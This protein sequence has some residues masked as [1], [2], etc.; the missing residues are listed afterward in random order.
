MNNYDNYGPQYRAPT[1]Q[2]SNQSVFGT[3]L[4]QPNNPQ[5][6]GIWLD[7]LF[8]HM[9][10]MTYTVN[11]Q[12]NRLVCAYDLMSC[13]ESTIANLRARLDK[14]HQPEILKT[15]FITEDKINNRLLY[16]VIK[17]D[18]SPVSTIVF[19]NFI[20]TSVTIC[21][22]D[23]LYN[24]ENLLLIALSNGTE[25]KVG[26]DDLTARKII[27]AM[28]KNGVAFSLNKKNDVIGQV[29]VQYLLPYIDSAK[30]IFI[31]YS[32][33]WLKISENKYSYA[34]C[35]PNTFEYTSPYFTNHFIPTKNID[36][37]Y[38]IKECFRLY[39][40]YFA[41]ECSRTIM[42]AS[43]IYS[44]L[45]SIFKNEFNFKIDK[46]LILSSTDHSNRILSKTANMFLDLFDTKSYA[47]LGGSKK[48]FVSC[49][50]DNKDC[51]LIVIPHK[52]ASKYHKGN[53][54][55]LIRSSFINDGAIEINKKRYEAAAFL[56]CLGDEPEQNLSYKEYMLL[57]ISSD[58]VNQEC[59]RDYKTCKKYWTSMVKGFISYVEN[60][61][62][63]LS[64]NSIKVPD[65]IS[66]DDYDT[67]KLLVKSMDLLNT[68]ALKNGTNLEEELTLTKSY[69]EIIQDYLCRESDDMNSIVKSF[70][71]ALAYLV[72]EN[73]L[74]EK[75][76]NNFSENENLNN[77]YIIGEE[78]WIRH[79]IVQNKILP[80]MGTDLK[81][82]KVLSYL[83]NADMLILNK[84]TFECRRTVKNHLK[85]QESFVILKL[86]YY[87]LKT[88][89][90]S[91]II[92]QNTDNSENFWEYDPFNSTNNKED[93]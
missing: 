53:C 90:A 2:Q 45:L 50:T 60:N 73:I 29:F 30:P 25:A 16:S 19:A 46:V 27:D 77:I 22:F 34:I 81:A 82:R 44:V 75:Y 48:T 14:S 36:I 37:G 56:V 23:K 33:G 42:L 71:D 78:V 6:I 15:H 52:N 13:M 83:K 62:E 40:E 63:N 86:E 74:Q 92:D 32:S 31:P 8:N 68:F 1:Q 41:D 66:A 88:K 76:N 28:N 18:G 3:P 38:G 12:A 35:E 17:N 80:Q 43:L 4:P 61:P 10:N 58:S 67:Y 70:L 49:I 54:I 26:L 51:P 24:S 79:Q 47:Y 59:I 69:C 55:D 5:N 64:P 65:T 11:D 93:I 91:I 7:N 39:K 72:A 21:E 57:D 89:S 87:P 9:S 20:V 84:G 85:A